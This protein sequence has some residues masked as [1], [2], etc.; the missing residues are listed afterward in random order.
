MRIFRIP[1]SGVWSHGVFWGSQGCG[2]DWSEGQI[3]GVLMAA[4]WSGVKH[5]V[6]WGSHGCSVK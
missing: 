6:F 3:F 2:V 4:V 5:R 1:I